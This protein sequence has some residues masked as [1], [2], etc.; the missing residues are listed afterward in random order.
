MRKLY[1]AGRPVDAE[2]R[3][4]ARTL[5]IEELTPTIPPRYQSEVTAKPPLV[6]VESGTQ[7]GTVIAVLVGEITKGDV[8]GVSD[9]PAPPKPID[10]DDA[11][12]TDLEAA[13]TITDLKAAFL[14]RLS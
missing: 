13:S 2:A 5:G 11:L 9:L 10:R 3:G 12:V 7:P 1:V 6:I 4:V 8:D 14:K